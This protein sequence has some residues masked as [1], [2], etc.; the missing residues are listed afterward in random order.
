MINFDYVHQD[1]QG[2]K[3]KLS[4]VESYTSKIPVEYMVD[5][6]TINKSYDDGILTFKIGFA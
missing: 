5:A 4:R 3:D 1:D 2:S 6:K